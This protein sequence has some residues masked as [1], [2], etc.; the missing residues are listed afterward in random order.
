MKENLIFRLAALA[1]LAFAI[2]WLGDWHRYVPVQA[3]GLLDTRTGTM[4]ANSRTYP[5]SSW[6]PAAEPAK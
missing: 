1:V 5:L 6:Q 4:Y 2:W 3:T